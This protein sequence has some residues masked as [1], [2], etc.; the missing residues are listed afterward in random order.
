MVLVVLAWTYRLRFDILCQ[1]FDGVEDARPETNVSDQATNTGGAQRACLD[2][3]PFRRCALIKKLRQ[4]FF[5]IVE[6]GYRSV[7][8]LQDSVGLAPCRAIP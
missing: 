2:P 8:T 6:S 1:L 3:Q 5:H 7:K 4:V